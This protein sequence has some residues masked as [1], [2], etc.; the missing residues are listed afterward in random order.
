MFRV[1]LIGGFAAIARK[2]HRRMT[3]AR[4]RLPL[5]PDVAHE[6]LE[7]LDYVQRVAPIEREI[8]EAAAIAIVFAAIAAEAYIFDFAARKLGDRYVE[9]NLDRLSLKS[10]WLVIPRLAVGYILST[11]GQAYEALGHLVKDRN[12]IVH[13]KTR[14]ALPML[15]TDCFDAFIKYADDID[16]RA[17]RAIQSLGILRDECAKFDEVGVSFFD[18]GHQE[19]AS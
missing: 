7:Y 8:G 17:D 10:K 16:K 3:E 13:H 11:D 18:E 14:D 15:E 5:E 4:N 6:S 2:H 9:K 12:T 19:E 1:G